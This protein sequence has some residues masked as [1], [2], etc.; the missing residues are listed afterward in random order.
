MFERQHH[1]SINLWLMNTKFV[2]YNSW[3]LPPICPPSCL[4]DIM[5][6]TK[7]PRP[8]PPFCTFPILGLHFHRAQD[9]EVLLTPLQASD[10]GGTI[11]IVTP[12]GKS[13]TQQMK[14]DKEGTA[15]QETN[16]AT[17]GQI[18]FMN[19]SIPLKR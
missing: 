7:S 13:F 18:V 12:N 11:T 15:V 10:P 8:S 19:F 5:H 6:V 9:K 16:P 2:S 4:P 3:A 14:T 1:C 17:P